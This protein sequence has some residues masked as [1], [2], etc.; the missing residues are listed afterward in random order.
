MQFDGNMV[1]LGGPGLVDYPSTKSCLDRSAIGRQQ[2][3]YR[4]NRNELGP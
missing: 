4:W 2:P 1:G 3:H